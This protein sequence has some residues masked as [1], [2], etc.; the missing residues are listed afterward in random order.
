MYKQKKKTQKLIIQNWTLFTFSKRYSFL[1][2]NKVAP[3]I[4]QNK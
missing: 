3:L 1:L 4:V 2:F